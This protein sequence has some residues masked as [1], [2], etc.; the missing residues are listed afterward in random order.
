MIRKAKFDD[1]DSLVSL[2]IEENKYNHGIAPDRV[3]QTTDVLTIRELQEFINDEA[4]NLSVFIK[5]NKPAGVIL[6][7]HHKESK[8]RWKNKRNYIYIE[9]IAVS[10]VYMIG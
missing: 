1:L 8:N 9:D 4:T 6:A 10:P 7:T 3:S 2:F 5:E